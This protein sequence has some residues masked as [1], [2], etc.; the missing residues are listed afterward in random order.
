MRA[1]IALMLLVVSALGACS[2]GKDTRLA[3]ATVQRIREQLSAGDLAG[4]YDNAAAD[5]KKSMSRAESDALLGAVNRKLGA[6]K[7]S[8]RKGWQDSYNTGGHFVELAYHTVFERGPADET[9][10]I[11]LA[12][13]KA[14]LA[15]YHI[16]SMAMMIN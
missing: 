8:E 6:L 2:A 5:W 7:T 13:N 15:G 3:E 14:T 9:F 4:I 1:S 12:D 16:N 11:R 10:T